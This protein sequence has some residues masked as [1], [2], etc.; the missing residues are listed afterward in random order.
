MSPTRRI[1]DDEERLE[2]RFPMSTSRLRVR[3]HLLLALAICVASAPA[4]AEE[5][6]KTGRAIFA[7]GCFWCM[8]KPFEELD[9]VVS[10]TSGYTGG[11][12]ENP[13]Y[14]DYG[15][16]G[17]VEAVEILYDPARTSYRQLLEVFWRQIDPTDA[18]GQFADRGR[19]Y[20]TA[21]FYLDEEQKRLAEQSKADLQEKR[22][23]DKAIVTPILPAGPFY[24]AEERHQDYYK[25]NPIRYRYYRSRSGRDGFLDSVWGEEREQQKSEGDLRSRLTPLQFRVTQ[26]DATEPPFRNEYWDNKRPGIYV[27]IVSGEVL[28]SS[29][30]KFDSGTGWPSFTRPLVPENLVERED[31]GLF[32]LRMEV[33]SRQADSHLGHVFEDGPPPTGL[34]YC[35]NSASLRFI[36]L[37]DLE[38][39]G[40]GRFLELF[41]SQ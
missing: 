14:E 24:R 12:T 4:V 28:F 2:G 37:N 26:E 11:G 41:Q 6:P 16:G 19:S 10:A 29:L 25:R 35:I 1:F 17:H 31:R 34:R 9:G 38:E 36:A 22:I 18:G 30:D 15:G 13:T 3:I 20:T 27:D 32:T 33:R 5:R 23:F 21:I 7:G 40:Y 8:E 39:E